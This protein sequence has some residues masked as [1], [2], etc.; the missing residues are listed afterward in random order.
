M[1]DQTGQSPEGTAI[2]TDAYAVLPAVTQRD[3]V[4][5]FLPGWQATR[6]SGCWPDRCRVS[7][8][9]SRNTRWNLRP[10]GGGN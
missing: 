1:P 2:F 4:T 10:K 9:P 8:K 7:P 5:S 6:A 3:I